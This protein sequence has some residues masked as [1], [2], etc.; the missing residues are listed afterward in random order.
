MKDKIK[1]T[2]LVVFLIISLGLLLLIINIF[3]FFSPICDY[4]EHKIKSEVEGK[5][6]YLDKEILLLQNKSSKSDSLTH[7]SEK[8]NPILVEASKKVISQGLYSSFDGNEL[9]D[10]YK[11]V[12]YQSITKI[13]NT[14][15]NLVG[16]YQSEAHGINSW[17]GT[18][19]TYLVLEENN[20]LY[21][22]QDIQL[23]DSKTSIFHFENGSRILTKYIRI[24][25]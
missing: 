2:L 24:K 7:Y 16:V 21:L 14:K 11:R 18:Y 22:I 3:L 25:K 4:S 13:N 15:F 5:V 1:K 8:C 19:L 17:G 23:G 20:E 12:G 9:G 6:I 10:F